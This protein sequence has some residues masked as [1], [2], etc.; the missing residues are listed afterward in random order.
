[1][2]RKKQ[3]KEEEEAVYQEI[4]AAR[5]DL[6]DTFLPV[7]LLEWM[8]IPNHSWQS[9]ELLSEQKEIQAVILNE[10]ITGFS[11][12]IHHMPMKEVY[13]LINRTLSMSIPVINDH[14]GIIGSFRDAGVEALFTGQ[15]EE[16]LNTAISICENVIRLG[17]REHYQNFAVGLC[18]GNVMAGVVGYGRKLSVLTLSPYTGLGELLQA[19]APGYYARILAAGSYVEKIRKFEQSYNHRLLGFF[20]IRAINSMEQIFDI[21]DGDP[22]DI[23]NRKRKTRMLFEKGVSLF[24]AREFAEARS[25]FIEVLK[26]DRDDKAAREYVFLCDKYYSLPPDRAEE[27]AIYLEC[28]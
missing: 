20:Y 10:N 1:M 17:D 2:R 9:E 22:T 5:E 23:R 6:L 25:Y 11:E 14:H 12:L 24:M 26:A 21:F 27:A 28:L 13:H 8:E 4:A 15:P 16:G 19:A 7:E 3:R 18:C